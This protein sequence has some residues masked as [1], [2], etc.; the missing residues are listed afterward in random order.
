MARTPKSPFGRLVA[1]S[2]GVVLVEC[3]NAAQLSQHELA[4]E[5]EISPKY[6]YQLEKGLSLPSLEIV[7]RLA[8]ALGVETSEMV[9]RTVSLITTA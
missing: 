4:T 5:A 8:R 3:R 7:I 1:K 2:F 9:G 6:L